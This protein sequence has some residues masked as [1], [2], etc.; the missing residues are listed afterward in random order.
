MSAP[1]SRI[2]VERFVS[3]FLEF[4]YREVMMVFATLAVVASSIL[5]FPG[6][7]NLSKG[8]QADI[9]LPLLTAFILVAVIAGVIKGMVGF[10]YALITTPIFASVIDPTFAV[11]VLAIPPW[12]I[13]MFQIG[14]TNTGLS[15]IREEWVLVLL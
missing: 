5:F 10:G 8:L 11:V 7:D 1:E 9:S 4:Q 13:N 6:F 14:E 2:D 3:N 12:M 15:F